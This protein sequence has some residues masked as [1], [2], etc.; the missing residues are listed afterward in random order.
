MYINYEKQPI[1]SIN[2]KEAIKHLFQK[3]R[4]RK[5]VRVLRE[6][7]KIIA[8]IYADKVKP[9]FGEYYVF[10]QMFY[11]SD[12]TGM[13]SYR[14]VKLLHEEMLKEGKSQNCK[15]ALA[16]SSHLDSDFTYA[17]MLERLNWRRQGHTA[18]FDLGT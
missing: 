10:Q 12:Q 2:R 7:N 4:T 8:W 3:V 16:V 9:P 6:E 14:C 11:V 1:I 15:Y 5:F 18:C 17:R 13:K